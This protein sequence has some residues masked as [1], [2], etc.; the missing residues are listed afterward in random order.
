M[1]VNRLL[2]QESTKGI[3]LSRQFQVLLKSMNIPEDDI[4]DLHIHLELTAPLFKPSMPWTPS[5]KPGVLEMFAH[6]AGLRSRVTEAARFLDS[7][8]SE[9]SEDKEMGSWI[10]ESQHN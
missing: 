5:N 3:L 9:L 10:A 7:S 1:A 4:G 6:I 2:I 8:Q